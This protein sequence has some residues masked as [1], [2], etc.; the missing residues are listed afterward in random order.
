MTGAE[1]AA[2]SVSLTVILGAIS[3]LAG[4]WF[5]EWRYK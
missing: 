1:I 5:A 3:Y 2:L 4:K